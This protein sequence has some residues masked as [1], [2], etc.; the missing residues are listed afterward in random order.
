ML[1]SIVFQPSHDLDRPNS[2]TA[3]PCGNAMTALPPT[4]HFA[5]SASRAMPFDLIVSHGRQGLLKLP[6]QPF[7][8]SLRLVVWP[9]HAQSPLSC[10]T[11]Y[12]PD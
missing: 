12:S 3:T 10:L 4:L 2:V 8:E 6:V 7:I 1:A 9:K 5:N 11:Q